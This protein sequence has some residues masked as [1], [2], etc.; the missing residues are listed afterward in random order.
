[1]V[2]TMDASA[3]LLKKSA[4]APVRVAKVPQV[5]ATQAKGRAPS[6]TENA[7][8][9]SS[10]R[11]GLAGWIE[12]LPSYEITNQ[13]LRS[14]GT[15]FNITGPS[16]PNG[17]VGLKLNIGNS[18]MGEFS[19]RRR[20]FS[21]NPAQVGPFTV[22]DSDASYHSFSLLGA[23]RIQFNK[24]SLIP[25]LGVSLDSLFVLNFVNNTDLTLGS[26]SD[27]LLMIGLSYQVTLFPGLSLY[28]NG[29]YRPGL[30]VSSSSQNIWVGHSRYDLGIELRGVFNKTSRLS[31]FVRTM[32]FLQKSSLQIYQ[33]QWDI[34]TT[35]FVGAVGIQTYF[36]SG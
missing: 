27:L 8:Q 6:S 30:G 25:R 10:T 4:P 20:G 14:T 11:L 34:T 24:T 17:G 15:L 21:I 19:Y 18:W 1:M 36:W 23:Y 28:F 35:S 32:T 2:W 7:P 12:Y 33:D 13:T 16:W 22:L 26:M 3:V 31:W 9:P 5:K 29:D